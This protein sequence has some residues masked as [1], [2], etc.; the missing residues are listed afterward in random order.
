MLRGSAN[1]RKTLSAYSTNIKQP[2]VQAWTGPLGC[3]GVVVDASK[4]SRKS[5]HEGG[6]VVS[7]TH[8]PPLPPRGYSCYSLLLEAVFFRI[9]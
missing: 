3:K 7:S 8:R 5:V 2:L 1:R 6:K 4:I 9:R